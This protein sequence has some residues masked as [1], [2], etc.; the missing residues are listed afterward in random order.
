MIMTPYEK[1]VRLLLSDAR[2]AM[3]NSNHCPPE[4]KNYWI[5]L[6]QEAAY[7]A[8]IVPVDYELPKFNMPEWGTYGT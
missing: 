1:E 7:K 2:H 6:A 5:K 8:S 3:Y 4:S